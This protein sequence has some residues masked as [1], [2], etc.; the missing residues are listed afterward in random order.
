MDNNSWIYWG[1]PIFIH[2]NPI[3]IPWLSQIFDDRGMVYR[4]VDPIWRAF[5]EAAGISTMGPCRSVLLTGEPGLTCSNQ[6]PHEGW[7][8][9][10]SKPMNVPYDWWNKH[11]AIPAILGYH[12][13]SKVLI[14]NHMSRWFERDQQS[15]TI[16]GLSI[17]GEPYR[18]T[19][20]HLGSIEH[21][22]NADTFTK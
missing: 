22:S 5:S 9:D 1:Y 12:L 10:G 8:G 11:P 15:L 7:Y 4:C 14:H 17:N 6:Q 3:I 19:K 13:G 21:S 20:S 2:N 16:L 18:P